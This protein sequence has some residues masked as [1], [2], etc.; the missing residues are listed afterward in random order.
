ME[1][2]SFRP[3]DVDRSLAQDLLGDEA[4]QA[5]DRRRSMAAPDRR[6]PSSSTV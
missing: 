6:T 3:D 4:R 5:L 2:G 1:R